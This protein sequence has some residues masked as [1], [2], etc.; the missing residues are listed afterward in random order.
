MGGYA[1]SKAQFPYQVLIRS[2]NKA[3]TVSIC[4]GSILSPRF[5]LTA[6]HCA[7]AY[8]HFEIGF[9]ST[10]YTSPLYRIKATEVILHEKFDPKLLS[11][12]RLKCF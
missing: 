6:A 8:K 7:K 1:A 3:N 10:S 9:G 4:G 2:F 12:V 5:V 11:N